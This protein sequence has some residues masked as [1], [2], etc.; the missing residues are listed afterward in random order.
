M[1]LFC[2][3]TA[4]LCVTV[5]AR[6]NM[7]QFNAGNPVRFDTQTYNLALTGGGGGEKGLLDS[8]LSVETFCDNFNNEIYVGHSD[9]SANISTLTDGSDL[10]NTRFAT[11]TSWKPITLNDG[12]SKD[13]TDAAT[14]NGAKTL[15][16]YQMAAYLVSNYQ[17]GQG[18]NASNNGI[19][20]AVWDIFDPSSSP[21][22]PHY[23]NASSALEKAAEWYTNP[24]SDKAI[25]TDF[26]IISDATMTAGSAGDPKNGGF[27]EQL[28]M[29]TSAVPEPR[30]ISLAVLAIFA[31]CLVFRRL[32]KAV[33]D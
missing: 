3:V 30:L 16:R 4:L 19:Q 8:N 25:L 7:V 12:N 31:F 15:A 26:L 14:I 22:A 6:A 1:R 33:N 18:S 28:T 20:G 21:S 29:I 27:Q 13:A 10:S 9:Y 11:T 5:A 2:T 32:A 23:A 17:M 24:N